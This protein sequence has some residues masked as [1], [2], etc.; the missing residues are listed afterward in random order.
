M[1]DDSK[2]AILS[3][4]VRALM[5]K[6][7]DAKTALFNVNWIVLDKG[8]TA[9]LGLVF[10][11]WVARYLGPEKYG[12]ISYVMALSA[13][14]SPLALL[15]LNS[16][17]VRNIV[18]APETSDRILGTAFVLKILG[19]VLLVVASVFLVHV[20]SDEGPGGDGDEPLVLY[21]LILGVGTLFRSFDVVV[22][23]FQSKVQGKYNAISN[24]VS[25]TL[26]SF[27]R[28]GLILAQASLLPFIV[29]LSVNN[30]LV[31][32]ILV[33][34]Y[35]VRTSHSIFAW[36]FDLATAKSLMKDSWPLAL[37]L[38]SAL[39]YL[40]I[41]QIMIGNMIGKAEL[42]IYSA[43]V[44]LTEVWNFVPA[45]IMESIFP[46][47]IKLR[48]KDSKVYLH[49]LQTV[50]DVFVWTT[51]GIG[52]LFTFSSDG[53]VWL[54]YGEKYAGSGTILAIYIWSAVFVFLTSASGYWL[55]A[56]NFMM[57][58]LFRTCTGAIVNVAL[59]L[60]FIPRWGIVGS[61]YATL[62]AYA[63]TSTFSL[64]LF[65]RTRIFAV[66][67]L[68]S[69]DVVRIFGQVRRLLG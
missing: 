55:I 45:A 50:C 58:G 65:K 54:L 64:L 43:A 21:L 33:F 1:R 62:I 53:L 26:C 38:V 36:R 4:R 22:Y 28:M 60:V 66:M 6:H 48:S 23:F 3:G 11:V 19:A 17:V 25:N 16:V 37:S 10:G 67:Q 63:W 61:A 29:V 69:L 13:L 47:I 8:V 20:L 56:E 30:I 31:I 9:L 51:V 15:G 24:I 46:A 35:A 68:R 44:R 7:P 40:K 41:D 52:V 49:R 2:L 39:I 42:G 34:F 32:S 12:I 59:N 57:L 14:L 5:Q 18:T 27:T